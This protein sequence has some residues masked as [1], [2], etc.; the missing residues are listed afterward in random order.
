MRVKGIGPRGLGVSPLKKTKKTKKQQSIMQNEDG[1]AYTQEQARQDHKKKLINSVQNVPVESNLIING[2]AVSQGSGAL[3][4]IGGFVGGAAAKGLAAVGREVLKRGTG[5]SKTGNVLIKTA[6]KILKKTNPKPKN[7]N[8]KALEA[9]MKAS[10]KDP[11]KTT[12]LS[13][14]NN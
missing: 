8:K 3:G 9:F 6:Q 5:P 14:Y 13:N 10:P 1:S 7:T 11:T 2:S 4:L 12:R